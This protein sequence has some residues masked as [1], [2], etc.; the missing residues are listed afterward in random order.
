M[1]GKAITKRQVD[2]LKAANREY[3]VWDR[4]L[5]GF[6][7]RVRPTGEKI[8]CREIPGRERPQSTDAAGNAGTGREAHTLFGP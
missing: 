8:L 1:L 6:G 5:K 4:D 2:A 3:F 7:L